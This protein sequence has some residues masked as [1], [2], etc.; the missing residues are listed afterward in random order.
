MSGRALSEIMAGVDHLPSPKPALIAS[1]TA[2][3]WS[4]KEATGCG[5]P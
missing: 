1:S 4:A 3:F 5:L 2:G